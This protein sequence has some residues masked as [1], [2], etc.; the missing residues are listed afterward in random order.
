MGR[1]L[2]DIMWTT[3]AVPVLLSDR[4]PDLLRSGGFTGWATYPVVPY[5]DDSAT[6][7]DFSG[8]A[9]TG[10]PIDSSR[11]Q[12]VGKEYLAG[13]FPV[14]KGL[15]FDPQSWDGSDIFATSQKS[16]LIFVVAAV[17]KCLELAGVRNILLTPLNQHQRM[18]P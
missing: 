2:T 3:M 18:R 8:L 1:N 15:Y 12:I 10:S 13:T 9:V 16:G 7:N 17:K 14:L 4:V 5:L 6:N 11:G